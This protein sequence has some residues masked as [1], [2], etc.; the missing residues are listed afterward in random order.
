EISYELVP[1]ERSFTLVPNERSDPVGSFPRIRR[2]DR[3]NVELTKCILPLTRLDADEVAPLAR[4]LMGP[5]GEVRSMKQTGVNQLVL[6]DTADNIRTIRELIEAADK[7]KD[8]A[9]PVPAQ[10]FDPRFHSG[11][12]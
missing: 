2:A 4:K 7:A 9:P 5:F 3:R 10:D 12:R 11:A 1:R 8:A 6:I